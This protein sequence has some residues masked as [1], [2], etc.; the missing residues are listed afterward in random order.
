MLDAFR[1]INIRDA[2]DLENLQYTERLLLSGSIPASSNRLLTTS[3]SN[4]GHFACL[5]MTG[6]Y[7]SLVSDDPAT[8]TGVSYLR[9]KLIDGANERPLFNDYIPL[10]LWLSPGR[11]RDAA[12]L[13]DAPVSN[14]LFYPT[15][16]QYIFPA[17]GEIQLDVWNDSDYANDLAVMF[18][19]I[20]IKASAAVRGVE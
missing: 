17:N 13:T 14:S 12:A 16:F 2:L 9:G 20:R 1:R 11:V 19:G 7:T 15:E 10:D 3:V 8:D 4:L 5:W 18:H 6:H